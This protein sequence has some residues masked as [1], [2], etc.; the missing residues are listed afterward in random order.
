MLSEEIKKFLPHRYP[1]LLVDRVLECVP[2]ERLTAIK[3]VTVTEPFFQGHFP[4]IAIMPGVLIIE[5]LAQATGLLGF[6]TMSETPRDDLLYML[7]GVD[8]VR[9]KRQVIP[10]D[11][12]MLKVNLEKKSRSIWK[13]TCEA[14]VDG[15]LVTTA[16]MLC[17]ATEK[18]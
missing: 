14:T 18:E 16:D 13:F 8:K 3:N 17:A 7:V 12:L 6:R 15:E 9:F 11:Q 5:A 1:F 10:G 2:G 4:Q